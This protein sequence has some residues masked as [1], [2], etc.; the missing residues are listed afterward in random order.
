MG[1]VCKEKI[2]LRFWYHPFWC[3]ECLVKW[4]EVSTTSCSHRHY[5]HPKGNFN[6]KKTRQKN[7][8]VKIS[9]PLIGHFRVL[10]CLCFK[11][12][13]SAK[14]FLWK[15]VL[16]AVSFSCKS[17]SFSKEWFALRL[18]LK[19]RH[20]GT[21]KWPITTSVILIVPEW[22]KILIKATFSLVWKIVFFLFV[23]LNLLSYSKNPS[24]QFQ[25]G[26]QASPATRHLN[27][28]VWMLWTVKEI[29]KTCMDIRKT[30]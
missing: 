22:V 19:Q 23:Y 18:A 14:P 12:S 11:A 25:E 27:K 16:H 5:H 3:T 8:E 15:W 20:E 28:L 26:S 24:I 13:L 2:N 21:R 10:L 4:L 29:F 9:L 30:I 17:K 1:K 6:I 7:E